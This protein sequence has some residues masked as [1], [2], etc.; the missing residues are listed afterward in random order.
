MVRGRVEAR[1]TKKKHMV[2]AAGMWDAQTQEVMNA[3]SPK[4]QARHEKSANGKH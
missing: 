1:G 2:A 3:K 4:D